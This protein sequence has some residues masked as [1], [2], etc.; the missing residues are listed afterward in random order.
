MNQPNKDQVIHGIHPVTEAL[1]SETAIEKVFVRQGLNTGPVRSIIS[2]CREKNI[3]CVYTPNQRL[4]QITRGNHQGVVAF[5]SHVDYV[6]LD[7]II[8]SAQLKGEHPLIIICDGI[9]DVRNVGA[10]AR[11]AYCMGAHGMVMPVKS[12]AMINEE[13]VKASAGTLL[14]LSVCREKSV[15]KCI[16]QLKLNGIRVLGADMNTKINLH[17]EELNLPLALLMGDEGSGVSDVVLKECDAVVKI[18]MTANAESLNV[19]VAAGIMLYE[20]MKQ[21]MH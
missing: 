5:L 11:S 14:K 2:A 7:D 12:G 19:S 6:T 1:D 17:D 21:R 9:T 15:M 3:P 18:P 8:N 4:N 10:I 13:A 20:V 16:E